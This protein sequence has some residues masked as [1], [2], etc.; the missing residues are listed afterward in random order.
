MKHK[1][2]VDDDSSEEILTVQTTNV[3]VTTTPEI[4]IT[5]VLIATQKEQMEANKENASKNSGLNSPSMTAKLVLEKSLSIS[6]FPDAPTTPKIGRKMLYDDEDDL[7][8]Q[9]KEIV[10]KYQTSE[11]KLPKCCD[12]ENDGDCLLCHPKTPSKPPSIEL[13]K[14]IIC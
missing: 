5:E 11:Q 1:W 13:D 3:I 10:K 14:G 7:N 6:N 9:V 4:S 12:S 2:L 8:S